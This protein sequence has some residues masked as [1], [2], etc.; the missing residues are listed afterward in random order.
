MRCGTDKKG[1][2]EHK[3]LN[4]GKHN[5]RIA[6]QTR[7]AKTNCVAQNIMAKQYKN[8]FQ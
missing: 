3:T 7:F 4:A 2:L 1:T 8:Q 5:D 6:L